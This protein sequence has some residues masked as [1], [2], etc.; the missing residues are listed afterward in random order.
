MTGAR[1][2]RVRIGERTVEIEV[3]PSGEGFQIV[4]EGRQI[5]AQLSAPDASGLRQLRIGDRSHDLLLA[6]S[7]ERYAVAL[8]GVALDVTVEDERAA[9]LA[10]FGG[11]RAASQHGARVTAPM[12]GL[13]VRVPVEVGQS[14]QEGEV[15]VVLQAMKMENELGSPA[16]GTVKQIHVQPGQPVEHGQVLVELQ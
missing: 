13:V 1:R 6:G 9:R 12:P 11:G 4:L 7:G 8:D 15:V 14:V 5:T 10:T 3:S 16:P 2:Y